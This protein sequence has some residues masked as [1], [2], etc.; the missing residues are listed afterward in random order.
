MRLAILLLCSPAAIGCSR[1]RQT[2][3]IP[4]QYKYVLSSDSLK[5]AV[6]LDTSYS[7]VIHPSLA[8]R[9][10]RLVE[11]VDYTSREL[12]RA[13]YQLAVT[14]ETDTTVLQ[15]FSRRIDDFLGMSEQDPVFVDA[16]FDGYPDI[17][18]L[19]GIGANGQNTA[20]VFYLFN[21]AKSCFEFDSSFTERFGVNPFIDS[22]AKEITTGGTTGCLG[23]CC[24]YETFRLVNKQF[25]LVKREITE[26]NDSTNKFISTTEILKEGRLV[27]T[28]S[29]TTD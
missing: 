24:H 20:Y 28:A 15:C 14:L 21:P 18:M 6:V 9:V 26:R 1:Q 7:M 10:V 23:R 13:S 3:G 27:V 5:G 12:D 16:N 29:D 2:H 4:A 8:S 17:Q 25:I 11:R 22:D 19:E